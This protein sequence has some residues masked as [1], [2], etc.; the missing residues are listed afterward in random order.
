MADLQNKA[1]YIATTYSSHENKVADNIRKRIENFNLSDQVFRVIVA[2]ETE[3]IKEKSGK[4]KTKIV[5]LYP[6]YVF[7]EMIM[8]D[9]TWYMVR[10]TPGVTGIAGSSGGGTKPTPVP[11][12]EIE[13]VLKRIGQI[14]STMMARYLVGEH[15]RVINGPFNGMEGKIVSIDTETNIVKVETVFFGRPTALE[16]DFSIIEKI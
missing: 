3:E 15:I 5:N 7:V 9:D 13:S 1:W 11:V 2:E 8:T 14:D 4:I 6:G 16:V 10:N 12:N